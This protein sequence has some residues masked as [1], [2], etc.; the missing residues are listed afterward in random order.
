MRVFVFEYV[1]GGGFADDREMLAGLVTE[2]DMMLTAVVRDLLEVPGVEV[3]VCRDARLEL[4]Q[5]PVEVHWVEGDWR[6]VWRTCLG[7]ADRVLPIAPETDGVLEA[8]CQEAV[9]AG[10]LLLN[11]R[12]EAV[13][14]AASKQRTLDRL[15]AHDIAVVPSWRA[16]QLP[17]LP[18]V[19]L[20][21]KPDRGVG[22]QDTHVLVG[23]HALHEFLDRRGDRSDWVVQI[24]LEGRVASL[25]LLAGDHCVCLLGRNLMRVVQ[26]DDRFLILGLDVNGLYF[27]QDRLL[28]LAQ[29]VCSAI[30]GLWGY[31]GIDLI[32]TEQGPVVLEVNPR[33]TTSYVGLSRSLG[34]NVAALLLRLADESS[35]LT[36]EALNGECVSVDVELDHVA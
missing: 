13:A 31:V 7:S 4:P 2:G 25:S 17:P 21:A 27:R 30:P 16:D 3:V 11:S 20:V 24:Y 28:E 5:L 22:S 12:T 14:L 9:A 19:A 15:A 32:M 35:R 36:A 18:D 8:L 23:E 1:T 29:A 34:R 26:M 33:L 10:K 6:S